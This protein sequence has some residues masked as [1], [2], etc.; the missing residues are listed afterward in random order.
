MLAAESPRLLAWLAG[1]AQQT[2]EPDLTVSDELVLQHFRLVL[3]KG[4]DDDALLSAV[5]LTFSFAATAG[6]IDRECLGYQSEALHSIRQRMSIPDAATSEPTLGAILLLAGIEVCLSCLPAAA[7]ADSL[8]VQ[9][10]LGMSSQVQ[11]H[12]QAIRQLLDICRTKGE[13]LSDGIKRAIF[14]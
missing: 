9:A 8:M 7:K 4:L 10:R 12:M 11:L 6:S 13:F 14:W 1:K 5:M 2:G 3:R